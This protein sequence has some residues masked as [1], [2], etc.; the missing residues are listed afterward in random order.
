MDHQCGGLQ[1]Y[2]VLA[3]TDPDGPRGGNVT[4]F[5]VEKA[6]AGFAF[7]EPERKLGIKGSHPRAALRQLP[8]PG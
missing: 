2:T 5:V 4:A 3:V 1:Y 8:D 6:D 7:G